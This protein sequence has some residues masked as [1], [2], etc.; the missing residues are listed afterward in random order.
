MER[1]GAQ[2]TM[3]KLAPCGNS[4]DRVP[5]IIGHQQCAVAG[6]LDT[7]WAAHG[8]V[9]G[10]QEASED[11]DWLALRTAADEGDEDH[12]VAAGRPPVPRAMLADED[13]ACISRPEPRALAEGEAE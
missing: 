10:V 4:P 5:D 11:I 1:C 7:D 12:L 13:A 6:D 3:R 2:V 9:A 8:V